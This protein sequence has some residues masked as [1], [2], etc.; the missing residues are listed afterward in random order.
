MS[1][2]SKLFTPK[3]DPNTLVQIWDID[4]IV[5][6]AGA[7]ANRTLVQSTTWKMVKRQYKSVAGRLPENTFDI[8]HPIVLVKV[9][10]NSPRVT[11]IVQT[12]EEFMAHSSGITE[13]NA[14]ETELW[15]SEVLRP[16]QSDVKSFAEQYRS[17]L[18]LAKILNS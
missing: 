1:F 5:L 14:A 18:D 7:S 6:P 16:L 12:V 8:L 9:T 13:R 15:R 11:V 4:I 2:F 3:I 10:V 17:L